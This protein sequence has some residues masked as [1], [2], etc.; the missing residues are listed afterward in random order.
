MAERTDK[1]LLRRYHENGDLAAR[2]QLIEQYMSLVRSLARGQVAV[3]VVA[4]Q[5]LLVRPLGHLR[6]RRS[7][8]LREDDPAAALAIGDGDGVDDRRELALEPER[9]AVGL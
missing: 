1:E 5:Q 8:V 3:L 4:P 6:L 7:H 9:L 2:E